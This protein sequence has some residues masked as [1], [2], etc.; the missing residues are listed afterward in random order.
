MAD[1]QAF[2]GSDIP[3]ILPYTRQMIFMDDG[4]FAVLD[5]ERIQVVDID[6]RPVDREYKTG[7]FDPVSAEKGGYDRFMQKEIF[8]QPRAIR[9]TI[10]TRI[11]RDDRAVELDGI[12]LDAP[13]AKSIATVSNTGGTI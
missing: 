12:D 13:A 10:G 9:D 8:E 5:E 3:A 2:I 6:G 7:N 11:S 4:D 1:G